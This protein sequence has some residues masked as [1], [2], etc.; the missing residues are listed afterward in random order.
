MTQDEIK[1][2]VAEAA[3]EYVET[4]TISASAPARP[5]TTS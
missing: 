3:I 2:K 5:Q 4:G 1:Q